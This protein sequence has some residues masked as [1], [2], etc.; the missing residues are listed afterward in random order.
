MC[1]KEEKQARTARNLKE[2]ISDMPIFIQEFF[3]RQKSKATSNMYWTYIRDMLQWMIDNGY[4][5]K[6]DITQVEESDLDNLT[7]N[8]IIAYLDDLQNGITVKKNAQST[9][10]TKK[11]ALGSFWTYLS[12]H[13]YVYDNIVRLIPGGRFSVETSNE[14]RVVT[15]PTDTE[16]EEFLVRLNDGNGNEFNI[17]RNMSIVKLIMGSGI[18]SEELI[19]LDICDLC[20]EEENPYI[21]V[22]GKGKQ[23]KKDKVYISDNA[24]DYLMEYLIVR[25]YFMKENNFIDSALFL[26]NERRRMGKTAITNFFSKYSDGKINPHMLRHWVGTELYQ[27]TKDIV[28]VQRQLRHSS[29]ETAAKYYVHMSEDTIAEAVAG[30]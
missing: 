2:K 20:L 10:D 14:E 21:M 1:Y 9:I 7:S 3:N 26:S 11:N 30:L 17:I 12:T 22:L 5:K 4:I 29:L 23:N 13:H 28:L 24:R 6:N 18:R 25:Q 19:N 16:L 8:N 27:K 15:V